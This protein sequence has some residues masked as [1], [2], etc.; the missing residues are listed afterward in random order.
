MLD[1]CFIQYYN[2]NI[3]FVRY[4]ERRHSNTF[5]IIQDCIGTLVYSVYSHFDCY[6]IS[7]LTML[8]ETQRMLFQNTKVK[9]VYLYNSYSFI[10][11]DYISAL[12]EEGFNGVIEI[13][14]NAILNLTYEWLQKKNVDIII[15]NVKLAIKDIP[16]VQISDFPTD[17]DFSEIKKL[18]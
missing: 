2:Y 1:K 15:S 12:L 4:I 18:L 10:H 14:G 5:H 11:R 17:R 6:D 13:V 3:Q 9:R 7:L 16:V 8:F